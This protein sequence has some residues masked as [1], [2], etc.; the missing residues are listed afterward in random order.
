MV[1]PLGDEVLV[2]GSID[3]L[4]GA[5]RTPDLDTALLAD[6]AGGA[7]T[8]TIRLPPE[9]RPSAGS[10][11]RVGVAPNAVRLFDPATGLAIEPT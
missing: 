1:E 11:L 3:R 2:H 8:V 6:V 4:D 10:R 7:S 5:V 9:G